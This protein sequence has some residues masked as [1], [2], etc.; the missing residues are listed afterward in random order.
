VTFVHAFVRALLALV[1][2]C[3]L[4]TVVDEWFGSHGDVA[5][6]IIAALVTAAAV[7]ALVVMS[8]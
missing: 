2:V 3:G 8:S 6:A 7:A 4:V 1:A 5:V